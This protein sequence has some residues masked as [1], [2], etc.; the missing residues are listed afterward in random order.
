M[1]QFETP[2]ISKKRQVPLSPELKDFLRRRTMPFMNY[3]GVER[4]LSFV[5]EEVYLQGMR[6]AVQALT[7]GKDADVGA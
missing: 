4:P 5:L 1:K 3:I 6:D 7:E 2:T